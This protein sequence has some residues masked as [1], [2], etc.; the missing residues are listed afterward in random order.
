[1]VEEYHACKQTNLQTF[2]EAPPPPPLTMNT[3]RCRLINRLVRNT[4]LETIAWILRCVSHHQYDQNRVQNR[5]F[6][7]L[8]KVKFETVDLVSGTILT[9]SHVI[10]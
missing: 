5:G 3:C 8:S 4:T 7:V 9:I 2:R 6:Y 1:M 10:H